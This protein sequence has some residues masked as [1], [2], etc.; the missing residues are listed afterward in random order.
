[1]P[2]WWFLVISSC[3]PGSGRST[4]LIYRVLAE[5]NALPTVHVA[6]WAEWRSPRPSDRCGDDGDRCAPHLSVRREP[7]G[8]L[9]ALGDGRE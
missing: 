7:P 3:P 4:V 8:D 2:T 9:I 1:M 5:S 6:A